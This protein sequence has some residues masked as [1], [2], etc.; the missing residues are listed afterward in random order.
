MFMGLIL[1]EAL[2]AGIVF[3]LIIWW[4]MFSGRKR[5]ELQEEDDAE[6]DETASRE[7]RRR[8]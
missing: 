6:D 8:D 3:V 7:P 2:G 5:G 4:T 1:L